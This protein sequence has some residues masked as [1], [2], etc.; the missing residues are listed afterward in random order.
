MYYPDVP[1]ENNSS[2][3][4]IRMAKVKQKISGCHRSQHGADRQAVLLSVMETAKRQNINL[5]SAIKAL[6]NGTLTFNET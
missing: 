2:E 3:R 5:F 1:F 6:L 4:A